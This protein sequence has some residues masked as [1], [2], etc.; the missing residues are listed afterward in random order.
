MIKQLSHNTPF[1]IKIGRR[2]IQTILFFAFMGPPLMGQEN[3]SITLL[4][5]TDLPSA[6]T[7]VIV[8]PDFSH[9]P[10]KAIIYALAIPGLGQAYNKKYFKIPIVYAALG[11]A[12]YAIYFNT[13][14]YGQ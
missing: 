8:E 14:E 9:S 13:N 4:S 12:G 11:V 2:I 6:D 7:L 3:D 5:I 10:S 1:R